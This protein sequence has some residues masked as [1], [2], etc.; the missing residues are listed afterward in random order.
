M[1]TS[2]GGSVATDNPFRR[3]R[4]TPPGEAVPHW[5]DLPRSAHALRQVTALVNQ[6]NGPRSRGRFVVVSGNDGTGKTTTIRQCV[7]QL[8]RQFGDSLVIADLSDM[9]PRPTDDDH[10]GLE[11]RTRRIFDHLVDFLSYRIDLTE[12]ELSPLR[13]PDRTPERGYAELSRLLERRH[14]Q[15]DT[16]VFVVVLLPRTQDFPAEIPQ[17]ARFAWQPRLI[18]FSE[19]SHDP[20]R[21]TWARELHD[22]WYAGHARLEPLDLDGYR[23]YVQARMEPFHQDTDLPIIP[24]QT[25]R[26][27]AHDKSMAVNELRVNLQRIVKKRRGARPRH[28]VT[29]N[30]FMEQYWLNSTG[31]LPDDESE[32]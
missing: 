12:A 29:M 1:T 24:D 3:P 7:A 19:T 4:P 11:E 5:V 8:K 18:F 15:A 22:M 31:V 25:L 6:Q 32:P 10:F 14:R 13:D 21:D 28:E 16:E 27:I 17:Y 30:D 23:A 26:D 20:T 2:S 9:D